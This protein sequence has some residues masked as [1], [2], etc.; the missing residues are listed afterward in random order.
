MVRTE[1]QRTAPT[2]SEKKRADILRAAVEEFSA[3][4]FEAASVD[5]I[6]AR[7]GVSKRTV[8]N[9][10]GSKDE[11][12]DTIVIE[13]LAQTLH[14]FEQPF[15]PQ[16]PLDEQLLTIARQQLEVRTST[17][18]LTATRLLFGAG[19]KNADM[20]RTAFEHALAHGGGSAAWM[21]EAAAAGALD[22]HGTPPEEAAYQLTALL[23]AFAC[24]PQVLGGLPPPDDAE[25]A[26]IAKNAVDLVLARYAVPAPRR[27]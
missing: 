16:A 5:D 25:Q 20:R 21:R 12:F 13:L 22:L 4:G 3:H 26:R 23:D 14:T 19:Y 27:G 11:L 8:Y 15:D 10:F 1:A 7:A 9:H 6:T 18:F 24:W 2:R 17:S